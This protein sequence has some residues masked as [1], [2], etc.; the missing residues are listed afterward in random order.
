M[1]DKYLMVALLLIVIVSQ[2]PLGKYKEPSRKWKITL[3]VL[4]GLLGVTCLV[5]G[6]IPFELTINGVQMPPSEAATVAD[7]V[8]NGRFF[9]L[10]TPFSLSS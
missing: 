5:F 9:Y 8:Y 6:M 4:T 2:L 10:L 7:I 3:A 1:N